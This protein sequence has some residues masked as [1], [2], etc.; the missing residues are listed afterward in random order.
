MKSVFV[1]QI[2]LLAPGLEGWQQ[3]L[4]VLK[5]EQP[6]RP[7]PL[8]ALAPTLLPANERRRITTTIK[9]ALEVAYT[10]LQESGVRADELH[11]VFASC[12]GDSDITD[13]LCRA[14]ALPERPVSPIHFHNSV[15]NAPAGYWAIAVESRAPSTSIAA[16]GGTFAAGL[17]EAASQ[18][19]VERAPVLLVAY[20]SQPPVTLA[21][22]SDIRA[23]FGLSVLL[24]PQPGAG[25][26]CA[27]ALATGRATESVCDGSLESLRL[28]NPAARALP[29]LAAIAQGH[30][31]AVLPYLDDLQLLAEVRPC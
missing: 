24:M 1:D 12:A 14:L 19:L 2:S 13:R 16:G 22:P 4:P 27:L 23:G 7:Q 26:C 21:G 5:G 20:D 11:C 30:G 29:L 31:T 10:A 8:P 17:L 18:V 25:T 6:Y 15:H 9:L 3:A 28:D